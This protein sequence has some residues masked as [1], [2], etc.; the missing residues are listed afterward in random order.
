MTELKSITDDREWR[1][2]TKNFR[3]IE[4]VTDAEWEKIITFVSKHENEPKIMIDIIFNLAQKFTSQMISMSDSDEVT[5]EL[6]FVR[7]LYY[8]GKKLK[9]AISV[10]TVQDLMSYF[11]KKKLIFLDYMV[12][13]TDSILKEI[14]PN[15]KSQL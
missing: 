4:D 11:P 13:L 8:L 1:L 14:N 12:L 15:Y 5:N 2:L 7:R 9:T 10:E 3:R 6:I